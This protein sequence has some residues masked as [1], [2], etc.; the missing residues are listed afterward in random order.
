MS[1]RLRWGRNLEIVGAPGEGLA[2][3]APGLTTFQVLHNK[4]N[5]INMKP[6]PQFGHR[7]SWDYKRELKLQSLKSH[8]L[9]GRAAWDPFPFGTLDVL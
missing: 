6:E 4:T 9:S 2:N 3:Q 7:L 5:S 1:A 8:P